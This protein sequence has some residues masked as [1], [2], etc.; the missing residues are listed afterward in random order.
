MIQLSLPLIW[1]RAGVEKI[2][3]RDMLRCSNSRTGTEVSRESGLC[4]LALEAA[5]I[6]PREPGQNVS[7][8]LSVSPERMYAY[9]IASE[10]YSGHYGRAIIPRVWNDICPFRPVGTAAWRSRRAG[11]ASTMFYGNITRR[12][13]VCSI[14]NGNAIDAFIYIS[15]AVPPGSNVWVEMAVVE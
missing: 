13:V 6:A 9:M 12:K 2:F 5:D 11:F 3:L 7:A 8:S 14:H 4:N 15:R 10:A 1:G